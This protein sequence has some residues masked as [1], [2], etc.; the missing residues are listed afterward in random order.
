MNYLKHFLEKHKPHPTER[1]FLFGKR[2][3]V[4]MESREEARLN[5][6]LIKQLTGSDAI[7]ARRMHE[8]NWTFSPTHKLMLCTNHKPVI[9]GTDH[10]I[11]RRPKLVPFEVRIPEEDKI[12]DFPTRLRAE[13]P[14]ILARCVRG[15]LDWQKNGL[16]VPKEVK[17]ATEKYRS[18]QDTLAVFIAE[19]CIVGDGC[20][21]KAGVMYQRYREKTEHLGGEPISLTRF[22]KAISERGFEK[23]P[24]NGIW[25]LGIGLHERD[26]AKTSK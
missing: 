2:L 9:R 12:L 8:D 24:N 4:A 23:E 5:E 21:A 6:A 16:G 18:E 13:Y 14:G 7:T 26:A 15:C 19:E 11:W 25:Y 22:G 10:A 20:R 1:A 17:D 3:V